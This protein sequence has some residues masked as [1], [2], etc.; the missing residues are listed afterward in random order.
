MEKVN[1]LFENQ[2]EVLN[3]ISSG[4]EL[5]KYLGYP[6]ENCPLIGTEIKLA[7]VLGRG[8]QGTVFLVTIPGMGTKEYVV[9]KGTLELET[10]DDTLES[11]K[12]RFGMLKSR[13]WADYKPFQTKKTINQ[14]ENP[15]T[16]LDKEITLIIPPKFCKLKKDR[17][18]DARPIIKNDTITV[19]AGSYLCPDEVYSEY[20][21]GVYT[22]QLY[23][24]GTCINFFNFYTFFAC[25]KRQIGG[26]K[27]NQYI[28][29]DKLDG[30]FNNNKACLSLDKFASMKKF[31]KYDVLNSIYIQTLFAIAAYQ[32]AFQISHNDLHDDNIFI[33]CVTP[34]TMF[35]GQKIHGADWFH[36]RVKGKDIYIA[37]S[38]GIVKIG[39]YGL[40]V[41]YSEPIVGNEYVFTDGY[42]QGDGTGAWIPDQFL[43]SYD[44]LFFTTKFINLIATKLEDG[45]N[46]LYALVKTCLSFMCNNI[47]FEPGTDIIEE[48]QNY[49]YVRQGFSN[50]PVLETLPNVKNAL[51]TLLGPVL[52]FS[53]I[54]PSY[55]RIVTLGVI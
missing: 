36:Y 3:I 7:H 27:Y 1:I 48:L 11:L 32:D 31:E 44:S 16:P 55:G 49:Q 5:V 23:R 38:P 43:P 37:A 40:S 17:Q 50:R 54:K 8:T 21:I 26:E 51:E 47:K 19:P 4:G 14:F 18:F 25:P 34:N 46:V 20:A 30:S 13:T 6:S 12:I 2:E 33:E 39:D 10:E 24:K 35:N 9:K 15:D 52:Q 41:K 45:S 29:M 22:G 53:S 28:L 42:D